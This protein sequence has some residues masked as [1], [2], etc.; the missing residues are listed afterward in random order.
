M[1]FYDNIDQPRLLGAMGDREYFS[2]VLDHMRDHDMVYVMRD[3][4]DSKIFPGFVRIELVA[5]RHTRGFV[6]DECTYNKIIYRLPMDIDVVDQTRC[7][8][9]SPCQSCKW[10]KEDIPT[11]YEFIRRVSIPIPR[12]LARWWM[13]WW[14]HRHGVGV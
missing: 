12:P 14:N 4:K 10:M 2:K 6:C 11:Y 8:C 3:C 5:V 1:G 13:N 7:C 9:A